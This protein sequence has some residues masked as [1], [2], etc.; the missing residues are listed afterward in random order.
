LAN[1]ARK[2]KN[3]GAPLRKIRGQFM[4]LDALNLV[5]VMS[6]A[7]AAAFTGAILKHGATTRAQFLD[8]LRAGGS[9]YPYDLYKAAGIDMATAGPYQALAARMNRL[10]DEYASPVGTK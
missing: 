5:M 10:M 6:L 8:M 3:D 9:D 1:E 7:V 4:G 2:M